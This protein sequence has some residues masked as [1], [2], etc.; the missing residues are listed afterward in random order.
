MGRKQQASCRATDAQWAN[1][2]VEKVSRSLTT[3]HLRAIHISASRR[4]GLGTLFSS[5]L[6]T[7][8]VR[9][10]FLT[11]FC[12]AISF[13]FQ[14]TNGPGVAFSCRWR[15]I[16][17]RCMPMRP[18]HFRLPSAG[19]D[20][21]RYSDCLKHKWVRSFFSPTV[22]L[23]CTSRQ[24]VRLAERGYS[25]LARRGR[26]RDIGDEDPYHCGLKC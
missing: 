3:G 2:K 12:I 18:L 8:L 6:A 4:L 10:D 11:Y 20:A 1:T 26:W 15:L 13:Q 9:V 25:A 14:L 16:M 22:V 7:E 23:W 21:H 24:R 17:N 19:D 5:Q